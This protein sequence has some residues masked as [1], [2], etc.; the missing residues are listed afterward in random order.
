MTKKFTEKEYQKIVDCFD[1]FKKDYNMGLLNNSLV[2]LIQEELFNDFDLIN[3][4]P[5]IVAIMNPITRDEAKEK[6][7]EKEKKYYWRYKKTNRY[8]HDIYLETYEGLI[9]LSAYKDE[10]VKYDEKFTEKE[11]IEAGYNPDMYEKEEVE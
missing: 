3:D 9:T 4:W 1:R 8:G 10:V 2:Y 11:V 7:V 5:E 6:Y